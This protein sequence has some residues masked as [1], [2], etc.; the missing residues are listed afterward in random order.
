MHVWPDTDSHP[1]LAERNT[2]KSSLRESIAIR[3]ART[4]L[5]VSPRRLHS[6]NLDQWSKTGLRAGGNPVSLSSCAL[7]PAG[8]R[9]ESAALVV[10][11]AQCWPRRTGSNLRK[12]VTIFS[13][14]DPRILRQLADFLASFPREASFREWALPGELISLLSESSISRKVSTRISSMFGLARRKVSNTIL[15][16]FPSPWALCRPAY[17]FLRIFI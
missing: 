8:C 10:N 7:R 9:I 13:V 4:F 14:R 11:P 3:S 6:Q 12:I 15:Y 5:A 17:I 2:Y 1:F 16:Y